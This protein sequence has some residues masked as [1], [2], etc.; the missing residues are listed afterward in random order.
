MTLTANRARR[1]A[2]HFLGHGRGRPGHHRQE[3][4]PR[5]RARGEAGRR[6]NWSVVEKVHR[7]MKRAPKHRAC[8]FRPIDNSALHRMSVFRHTS[9]PNDVYVVHKYTSLLVTSRTSRCTK[10]KMAMKTEYLSS[11]NHMISLTTMP[12]IHFSKN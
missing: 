1:A 3:R 6:V 11:S 2:R 8:A 7:M 4:V 12:I 5:V 10:I 9:Q